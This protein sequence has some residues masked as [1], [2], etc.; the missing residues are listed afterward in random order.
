MA[1]DWQH[2]DW[3]RKDA[4]S[5]R[6]EALLSHIEEVEQR[7]AGFQQ[8]ESYGHSGRR[9][10]L[11]PYLDHLEEKL[12]EINEALGLEPGADHQHFVSTR[13]A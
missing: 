7:M 11:Q 5:D 4:L 9:Y 3:R 1:N 8:Q 10:D 6:R 13:P 12:E 2:K